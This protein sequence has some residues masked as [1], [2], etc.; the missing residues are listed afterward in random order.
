[1]DSIVISPELESLGSPKFSFP[2]DRSNKPLL[3]A[4]P[5]LLSAG[6][7]LNGRDS[8]VSIKVLV[9]LPGVS[10]PLYLAVL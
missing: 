9:F 3:T 8:G 1:M 4:D 5:S 10:S 7:K 2:P 6:E